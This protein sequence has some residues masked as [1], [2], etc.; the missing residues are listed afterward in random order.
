MDSPSIEYLQQCKNTSKYFN[1]DLTPKIIKNKDGKALLPGSKSLSTIFS[2]PDLC[3]FLEK[4]LK[5]EPTARLTP[6]QALAE[7]WI[8][9]YFPEHMRKEHLND[10]L[11]RIK[12]EEGQ[13][14]K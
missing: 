9:G 4:I 7:P 14:E 6:L 1:K 10:V 8:L 3:T 2:D 12:K 13:V 5:V 11:L